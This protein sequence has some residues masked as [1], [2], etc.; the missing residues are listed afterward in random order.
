M[1]RIQT[2]KVRAKF[3]RG[4][5]QDLELVERYLQTYKPAA[6]VEF[7]GCRYCRECAGGRPLQVAAKSFLFQVKRPSH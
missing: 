6:A 2:C 4:N 7:D 5:D 1:N 3:A